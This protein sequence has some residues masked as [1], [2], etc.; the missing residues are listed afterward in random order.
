[1][2][3]IRKH[4]NEDSGLWHVYVYLAETNDWVEVAAHCDEEEANE[5]IQNLVRWKGE[6]V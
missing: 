6:T 4:H 2:D 5:C 3:T 1:M